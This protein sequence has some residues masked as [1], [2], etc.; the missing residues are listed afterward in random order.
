M[1]ESEKFT[2]TNIAG[3][4]ILRYAS[5]RLPDNMGE[6]K[7]DI[8]QKSLADDQTMYLRRALRK[9]SPV[10][11]KHQKPCFGPLDNWSEDVTDDGKVWNMIDPDREIVIELDEEALGG[12]FW[13]LLM[14]A[15][16]GSPV[17]ASISEMDELVWD[18]AD[19]FGWT[20]ELRKAIHLDEKKGRVLTRQK[21]KKE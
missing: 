8:A 20:V 13:T 3:Q 9:Y 19:K 11:A 10:I 4:L 17:P 1:A 18:L 12:L 15:H 7:F 6:D 16:P 21:A 2:I 5:R 14:M